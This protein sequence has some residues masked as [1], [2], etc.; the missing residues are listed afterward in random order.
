[1]AGL[2][3]SHVMLIILRVAALAMII[4]VVVMSK[5]GYA[6]AD[7]FKLIGGALVLFLLSFIFKER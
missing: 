7:L 6:P 3:V 4:A 1:M 2:S 5:M